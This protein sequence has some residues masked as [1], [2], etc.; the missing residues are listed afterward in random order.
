MSDRV[1]RRA[2]PVLAYVAALWLFRGW[3]FAV[4]SAVL[5]VAM[6]IVFT[7]W[8]RR[9]PESLDHF[10]HRLNS[11]LGGPPGEAWRWRRR[12][13]GLVLIVVGLLGIPAGLHVM[14]EPRD[15]V[16]GATGGAIFTGLA[17][18]SLLLGLSLVGAGGD[19]RAQSQ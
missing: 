12:T 14:T 15:F 6:M 5:G 13:R 8:H 2:L 10:T 1:A 3:Q 9:S 7:A 16:G 18:I 11:V 17:A 4:I 19:S